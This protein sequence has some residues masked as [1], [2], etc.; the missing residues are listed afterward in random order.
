MSSSPFRDA[1]RYAW[2][3]VVFTIA[4]LAASI[5]LGYSTIQIRFRRDVNRIV[6]NRNWDLLERVKREAGIRNDSLQQVL[7]SSPAPSAE[8]PYIVVSIADRRLWYKRGDETLYTTRVAVGS[9]KTLVKH[10]GRSEYKFD[11]PRGR[12]VVQ[13]KEA[14]PVWVPPDWHYL[15]LARR[16]GLGLLKLTRGQTIATPDGAVVTVSGNDVVKRFPDGREVAFGSGQEGKEIIAGGNV[17]VPPFGTNQRKYVGVLGTHRLNL[18]D[19]YAL[20][21]TDTPA[22]IGH[23]VSHGCVRLRNED[24]DYLYS[25]V[26]PGTPVYIY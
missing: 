8:Q 18:G 3:L 26:A 22:S 11:T 15:E 4:V 2:A 14:D 6:F 20:H 10:G 24:I 7:A 21:G 25:S 1:P 13:S 17:I 23:A 9:G 19:G 12:L 5:W 16:K